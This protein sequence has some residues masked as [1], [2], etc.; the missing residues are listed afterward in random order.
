[1]SGLGNNLRSHHPAGLGRSVTRSASPTRPTRSQ[2]I[3]DML[4]LEP[5]SEAAARTLHRRGSVSTAATATVDA[6][7][8]TAGFTIFPTNRGSALNVITRFPQSA[9]VNSLPLADRTSSPLSGRQAEARRPPSLTSTGMEVGSSASGDIVDIVGSPSRP[10]VVYASVSK[11]SGIGGGSGGKQ[12]MQ[13]K[14]G[15]GGKYGKHWMAGRPSSIGAPAPHDL[16]PESG[17]VR[18]IRS[19]NINRGKSASDKPQTP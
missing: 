13:E 11:G 10:S 16:H 6:S 9:N 14:P 7:Q 4:P 3:A 17:L 8:R 2:N 12:A 1:M 5:A 19:L 15:L 18:L